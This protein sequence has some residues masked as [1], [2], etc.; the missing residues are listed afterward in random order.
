MTGHDRLWR[1]VGAARD[2]R[3]RARY[4]LAIA[5]EDIGVDDPGVQGLRESYMGWDFVLKVAL[6]RYSDRRVSDY[7]EH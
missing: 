3:H 5:T 4:L 7:L 1:L 6:E 2:A